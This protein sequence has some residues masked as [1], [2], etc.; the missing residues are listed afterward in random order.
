MSAPYT[1]E[2]L[3]DMRERAEAGWSVGTPTLLRL[4]AMAERLVQ[5]EPVV[6]RCIRDCE[7]ERL[8]WFCGFVVAERL[9]EHDDDCPLVVAELLTK[10][11]ERR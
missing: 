4:I 11:G 7:V 3:A 8:C 9:V 6:E 1:R 2:E 5:V 10:E